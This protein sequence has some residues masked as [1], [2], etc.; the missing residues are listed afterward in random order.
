MTK[1]IA[2]LKVTVAN[3]EFA[4]RRTAW[5]LV[6]PAEDLARWLT[7]Y[8]GLATRGRGPYQQDAEAIEAAMRGAG[9]PV[10]AHVQVKG[11]AR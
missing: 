2:P 7:F 10:P 9:L 8:R 5:S 1:A 11:K 4:M 3:G 6:G